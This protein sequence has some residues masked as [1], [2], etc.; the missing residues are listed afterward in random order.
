MILE[1]MT[2][3]FGKLE[4][5]TLTFQPGLNV[6]PAPNEWGKS[7]WCAFL[8]AMLYGVDTKSRSTQS[9]LS[10]K[11]HYAPWSGSPMSGKIELVWNDRRIT[12]ERST[13]GRIP[14]GE[15]QA[16]ETD[17]GL[18]VPELTAANC[19]QQLLGV[20]RSV[21]RRAGF[22][23]LSDLPV[24]A[25]ED[26]R[27]RLNA[28]VTTGD[29]SGEAV[30]LQKSLKELKSRICR[31]PGGQLPQLME[32]RAKLEEK[33]EEMQ[34]KQQAHENLQRQLR[35]NAAE[36]TL[37]RNHWAALEYR[38]VQ[39]DWS[40]VQTA[41]AAAQE[42]QQEASQQEAAC[43]PLPS[44]QEAQEK[45]EALEQL[46][47]ELY[48]FQ[49]WQQSQPMP[50]EQPERR[51]CFEGL[52]AEEMRRMVEADAAQL[53]AKS[54]S[55]IPVCVAVLAAIAC[56]VL[57]VLGQRL[58]AI[59]SG[60]LFGISAVCALVLFAAQGR[61]KQSLLGKYGILEPDRWREWAE[62]DI[63]AMIDYRMQNNACR[64]AAER[65]KQRQ[66]EMRQTVTQ[67]CGDENPEQCRA[68]WASILDS[69]KALDDARERAKQTKEQFESLKAMARPL[70][71]KPE[72]DPCTETEAETEA[73]LK[74]L[75]QQEKKLQEADNKLL[76]LLES[77]G[78]EDH[79]RRK[80]AQQ[81][82]QAK[83]LGRYVE[84]IDLA[85]K[86][87]EEASN[88]LQRRFAPR[89]SQLGQQYLRR[90]TLG[91]YDRL[92]LSD[93]LALRCGGADETTLREPLWRS[94]GTTDQLYLALRLAVAQELTP[95]APLILDDA[96]VRFDDTRL[97]AA[98]GLLQ[99]LAEEKQVILFT[100][101]SREQEMLNM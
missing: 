14:L 36:Q 26:L 10:D 91:R 12:I 8:L 31:K 21:F 15:F 58:P 9:A 43:G 85:Q 16:Y 89:I 49:Q 82:S 68:H 65:Q 88:Q 76:G 4:G 3:T 6:I 67:V 52:S 51:P 98:L 61:K 70:P 84:A 69:W 34:E 97:Q 30:K 56:A 71:K 80:L 66:Q 100:C 11:E 29:E 83:E 19:G 72:N 25:D 59:L 95:D 47:K 94:E 42:A 17:S 46:R 78:N 20:E 87:L 74:Q 90:L 28:L 62:D 37:L 73:Q 22:I 24:T 35:E 55:I 99:E 79:L 44:R 2:A 33:L 77:M 32:Q 1:S 13:K 41:E 50:P 54:H 40:R 53:Q 7:T 92:I 27:R 5:Q 48:F 38:D 45:L 63:A 81:E 57:L 75:R 93:N 39:R 101:Q 64:E 96:F 60:V 23:R 18:S 86:T